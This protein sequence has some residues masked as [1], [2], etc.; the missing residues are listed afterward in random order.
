MSDWFG[1]S[2][3]SGGSGTSDTSMELYG[4]HVI[5]SSGLQRLVVVPV[6]SLNL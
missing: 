6:A 4:R 1:S 2:G 3:L 5:P